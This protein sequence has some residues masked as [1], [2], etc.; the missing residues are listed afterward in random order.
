[1]GQWARKD[2]TKEIEEAEKY[3]KELNSK[4]SKDNYIQKEYNG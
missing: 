2:M 4:M 1:M 3:M